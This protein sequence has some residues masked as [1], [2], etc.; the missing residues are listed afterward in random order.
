M[1]SPRRRS[2]LGKMILAAY[3]CVF[4]AISNAVKDPLGIVNSKL[5][6]SQLSA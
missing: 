3:F 4:M 6:L 2:R 5:R 1:P